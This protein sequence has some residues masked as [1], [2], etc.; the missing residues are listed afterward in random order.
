MLHFN[1]LYS[2]SWALFCSLKHVANALDRE[3]LGYFYGWCQAQ[4]TYNRKLTEDQRARYKELANKIYTA[5]RKE[6]K[7]QEDKRSERLLS[8]LKSA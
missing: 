7:M 4:V 8:Y 1:T 3:D 5:K 6:F 2:D